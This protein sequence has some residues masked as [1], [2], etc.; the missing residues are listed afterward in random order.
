MKEKASDVIERALRDSLVAL[1]DH[2]SPTSSDV[3]PL[4]DEETI[5]WLTHQM[6]DSAGGEEMVSSSIGLGADNFRASF[7]LLTHVKTSQALFGLDEVCPVDWTGELSNQLM[8]RVKNVLSEYQINASM[9]LPVSVRGVSMGFNFSS[10]NQQVIAVSAAAGR[11]ICVFNTEVAP[12]LE[13]EHCE[14][15]AAADEGSLCMF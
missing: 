15:L 7:G 2:Y 6:T 14:D 5:E 8:G 4:S 9:S 13:W 11:I 3:H 1:F 10:T 12:N